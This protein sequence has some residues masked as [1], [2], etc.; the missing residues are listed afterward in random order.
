MKKPQYPLFILLVI[1]ATIGAAKSEVIKGLVAHFRQ[2]EDPLLESGT[3]STAVF[4]DFHRSM[5]L[6][7]EPQQQ[8]TKALSMA[9]NRINGATEFIINHAP[10]W[11]DQ[12]VYNEQLKTMLTPALVSPEI[13][14]R[15]AAFEIYL[16]SFSLDKSAAQIDILMDRFDNEPESRPWA[17]WSIGLIAARGVERQKAFDEIEWQ[18]RSEDST[19]RK[20][21]VNAM[22]ILGGQESILP[23]LDIAAND[24]DLLVRERAFCELANSGTL[25]IT[26][27]YQAIPSLFDI[28]ADRKQSPQVHRWAFQALREITAT[29]LGDDLDLWQEKLNQLEL[30]N[31]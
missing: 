21:A 3:A 4:D 1:L 16:A 13:A 15:M 28:A 30:L 8:V 14:V 17:I 9:I 11:H 24:G 10:N 20:W 12:I 27:R 31:P 26:E 19:T 6:A 29:N 23:L 25:Q 2:I 7:L 5:I 22:G 18:I